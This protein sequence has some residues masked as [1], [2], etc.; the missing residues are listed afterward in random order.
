L[1]HVEDWTPQAD[2][3]V[4][5]GEQAETRM[6]AFTVAGGVAM[7][8]AGFLYWFARRNEPQSEVSTPTTVVFTGNG[9]AITGKF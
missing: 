3:K 4:A 9:V 6:I 1:S 8:T 5:A 7:A 2:A